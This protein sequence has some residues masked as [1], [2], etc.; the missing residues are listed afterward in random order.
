MIVTGS[1]HRLTVALEYNSLGLP[2][3]GVNLGHF[4]SHTY[5]TFSFS[6]SKEKALPGCVNSSNFPHHKLSLASKPPN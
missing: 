5:C 2:I 4:P 6:L 1:L 3:L